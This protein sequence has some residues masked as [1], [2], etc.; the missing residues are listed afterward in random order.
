MIIC[1]CLLVRS[2]H[3]FLSTKMQAEIVGGIF[4]FRMEFR[5]TWKGR[6]AGDFPNASRRSA[7]L[8]EP[9]LK[10]LT[11]TPKQL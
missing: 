10:P 5:H 6:V 8:F 1:N 7:P 3:L 4:C 9:A 11:N 2:N